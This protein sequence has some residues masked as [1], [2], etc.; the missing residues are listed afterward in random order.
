MNIALVNGE[1]WIG[2]YINGVL[3]VESHSLD[4]VGVLKIVCERQQ[5]IVK[6]ESYEAGEWLLNEGNL[7]YKLTD[8]LNKGMKR[9][10]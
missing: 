7:P 3:I 1:D 5:T 9:S 10:Y 4:V 8:A 2:L 6:I